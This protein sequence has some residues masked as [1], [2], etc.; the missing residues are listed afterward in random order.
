MHGQSQEDRDKLRKKWGK[1][2]EKEKEKEKK[3]VRD[4]RSP[5]GATV[6]SDTQPWSPYLPGTYRHHR[7]FIL[8]LSPFV[9]SFVHFIRLCSYVLYLFISVFLLEYFLN[10][11]LRRN[12]YFSPLVFHFKIDFLFIYKV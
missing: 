11:S 6:V 12:W 3:R 9:P 8:C 7:C 2:R 10:V 1:K 5:R 4:C